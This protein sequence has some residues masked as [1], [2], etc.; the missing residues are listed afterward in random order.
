MQQII[1]DSSMMR[2]MLLLFYLLTWATLASASQVKEIVGVVL[3]EGGDPIPY[4]T[5]YISGTRVGTSANSEGRFSLSVSPE[6]LNQKDT[7]TLVVR[8]VGYQQAA[9]P[10]S[11]DSDLSQPLEVRLKNENFRI[12]E[13]NIQQR[14]DPAYA[15]I[16]QAIK[17]RK[18]HLDEIPPY[19]AEV[20][21]KGVQ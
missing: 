13:V 8:A 5:L 21:I 12:E 6:Y 16:R 7:L 11:L 10:F 3:N 17:N 2:T 14:E 18:K 19:T 9:L 20:Y 1:R 4:A 15:I